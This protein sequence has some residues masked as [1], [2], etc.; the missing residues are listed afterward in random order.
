[1]LH[2]R[3]HSH[4]YEGSMI[5]SWTGKKTKA[6]RMIRR[7]ARFMMT[8]LTVNQTEMGP[9]SL[10]HTAIGPSL[11]RS[12]FSFWRNIISGKLQGGVGNRKLRSL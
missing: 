1:M 6:K 3:A 11:L 5:T 10:L 4:Q 12:K 7:R 9:Y 8:V 2:W